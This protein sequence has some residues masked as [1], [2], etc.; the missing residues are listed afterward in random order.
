MRRILLTILALALV[1]CSKISQ[2]DLQGN[3]HVDGIATQEITSN[4]DSG[5]R[6]QQ[7]LSPVFLEGES[8]TFK[9]GI[10]VPCPSADY[11]LEAYEDYKGEIKY[12]IS[13][14]KLTIPEIHYVRYKEYDNGDKEYSETTYP[15]LTFEVVLSGSAIRLTGTTEQTDNLGN[16]TKRINMRLDL[17]RTD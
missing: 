9:K 17:T 10:L 2:S 1:S 8:L 7:A 16:V 12:S 14:S 5:W 15:A 4:S 6:M 13:G 3:W 11:A